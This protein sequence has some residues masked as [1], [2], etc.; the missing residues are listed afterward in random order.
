[1][2]SI[3]DAQKGILTLKFQVRLEKAV[4]GNL[5]ISTQNDFLKLI[6]ILILYLKTEN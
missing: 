4:Y 1:M 3:L 2:L 6:N 5:L